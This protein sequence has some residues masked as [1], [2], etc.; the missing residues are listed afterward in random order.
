MTMFD[1]SAKAGGGSA[2][3]VEQTVSPDE[4]TEVLRRCDFFAATSDSAVGALA[5]LAELVHLPGGTRLF[6]KGEAGTAIYFVLDGTVRVHQGEVVVGYLAAGEVFG[7]VAGLSNEP[8]SA[9]VTAE[10]DARLL[11]LEQDAVYSV[12]ADHPGAARSLIQALCVRERQIINEKFDRIV[13]SRLLEHEMEIGQKIQRHF[14]PE[15][16]P[17]IAGWSI[18]G[19]LRPARQV[20]GDFYDFFTLP[21]LQRVGVVIGDVCDKG[22]GA[23]LFMTLFRSLLRSAAMRRCPAGGEERPPDP[24]EV[25]RHALDS[26]NSYLVTTHSNSSMFASVFFGLLDPLTGE[27]HYANAGHEAPVIVGGDGIRCRLEST[28]PVIGLFEGAAHRVEVASLL[29]GEMLF[30]Y[31]DGAT[32]ARNPLAEQ[33]SEERLLEIACLNADVGAEALPPVLA[34]I[35]AFVDGAD[36]YDDITMICVRRQRPAM[37]D[38]GERRHE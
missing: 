27:L 26:T 6:E 37:Q 5:A 3:I 38:Q 8:R 31:T 16:L 35:E 13:R 2:G 29:P 17:E 33:F 11:K 23:A 14:L 15:V 18:E 36:Q 12:L 4:A 9:S 1:H 10:S 24:A 32:D 21:G 19:L 34:A 28:G 25:L 22:V 7:E 20:A 30:G